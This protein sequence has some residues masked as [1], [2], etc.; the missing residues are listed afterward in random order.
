MALNGKVRSGCGPLVDIAVGVA[1]N[2]VGSHVLG[3][4]PVAIEEE[5]DGSRDVAA[6]N[7]ESCGGVVRGAQLGVI[8]ERGAVFAAE[9]RFAN[10]EFRG[11]D[12]S[13]RE[14][15]CGAEESEGA[16]RLRV[17]GCVG[18]VGATPALFGLDQFPR[19]PPAGG[20]V[21]GLNNRGVRDGS[22]GMTLAVQDAGGSKGRV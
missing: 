6:F 16:D 17:G 1:G 19:G 14:R 7:G 12:G 9:A 21:K 13:K 22:T 11:H 2:H 15:G 4:H 10:D 8:G 20:G 5:L 3:A 18:G